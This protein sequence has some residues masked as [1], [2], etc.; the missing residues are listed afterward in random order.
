MNIARLL[1][2]GFL[3]ATLIAGCGSDG[4]GGGSGK[5]ET[6]AT[7]GAALAGCVTG[8]TTDSTC[9]ACFKS[10]CTAEVEECYGK[11]YTGG[12]CKALIECAKDDDDPCNA[13]CLPDEACTTCI[14]DTLMPCLRE[15]C[16]TECDRSIVRGTCADLADCCG[17]VTNASVKTGCVGVATDGN[18]ILCHSYYGS[19]RAFCE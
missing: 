11:G 15:N 16:N 2:S 8:S 1:L 18:E 14:M 4:G 7:G 17:M 9:Q 13:T 10:K 12:A 19:V 3:A 5:V 6:P